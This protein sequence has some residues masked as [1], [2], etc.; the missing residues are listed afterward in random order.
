MRWWAR[1]GAACPATDV[2]RYSSHTD[3]DASVDLEVSV[4]ARMCMVAGD[5]L[6]IANQYKNQCRR[7]G[8]IE[9]CHDGR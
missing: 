1:S 4:D 9:I 5:D 8:E 7:K 2:N 6:E 3:G